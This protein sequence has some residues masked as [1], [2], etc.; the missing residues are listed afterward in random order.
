MSGFVIKKGPPEFEVPDGSLDAFFDREARESCVSVPADCQ[1]DAAAAVL[2][3]LPSAF[4]ELDAHIHWKT[5]AWSNRKEQGGM[6]VGHVCRDP[7]TGQICGVAE[8]VIPSEHAGN[9]TYLQ[10]THEDWSQMLLTYE[11]RFPQPEEEDGQRPRIIGWYHTHPNMPTHMSQI[12]KRTHSSFWGKE[13]QFS[14]IF[15]PQRGSWEVF[16][17]EECGNC[18]GILYCGSEWVPEAPPEQEPGLDPPEEDPALA[19]AASASAEFPLSTGAFV[20]KRAPEHVSAASVVHRALV[21]EV[22]PA[23]SRAP[24]PHEY[25]S[26]YWRMD[27]TTYFM[28][29]QE[30]DT[31]VYVL[32]S[33]RFLQNMRGQMRKWNVPASA[34]FSLTCQVEVSSRPIYQDIIYHT[35]YLELRHDDAV[36]AEG[37][38][39]EDGAGGRLCFCKN[40]GRPYT[41]RAV[42]TVLFSEGFPDYS[43]LCGKYR[44]SDFLLWYSTKN[45][46]DFRYFFLGDNR[47]PRPE[48]SAFQIKN[49]PSQEPAPPPSPVLRGMEL[50]ARWFENPA[51]EQITVE[52][53][54]ASIY[55]GQPYTI[56]SRFLDV[57]L[58]YLSS[59]TAITERFCAAAGYADVRGYSQN[60]VVPNLPNSCE[61]K[62]FVEEELR[63]WFHNSGVPVEADRSRF[64]LVLANY[65]VD[66]TWLK[67]NV[68][69]YTTAFCVDLEHQTYHFYHMR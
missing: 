46:A 8:H 13:W 49:H 27:S 39:Y 57:I 21:P 61:L 51:V 2:H 50:S 26:R 42:L 38:E 25:C 3:L 4:L 30:A 5:Q 44:N 1:P 53:N 29:Y 65:E 58:Q 24:L 56:S 40:N 22:R 9:A 12:D 10:F 6:M 60:A 14:A 37:F 35:Y 36:Y 31:P 17:G 23:P 11:E 41:G 69:G 43:A 20:I 7:E 67:A 18:G 32:V 55:P 45:P 62:I 68:L 63:V 34:S 28:P 54:L 19:E 64:L 15:N 59:Y 66:A 52:P 48:A 33:E 47:A 16:N